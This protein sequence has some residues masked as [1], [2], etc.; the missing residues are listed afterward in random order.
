MY[1]PKHFLLDDLDQLHE[2]MTSIAAA[3]IVSQSPEGLVASHVPVELQRAPAPYGRIRC[4]LARANSHAKMIADG[5]E[6]L[7]IFQGNEG[8]ISPA[9]YPTKHSNGGKV[10][11]TWNFLAIHAYGTAT[12]FEGVDRLRPHLE[13]L[14]MR[15]E[16]GRPEP[17]SVD[18]APPEFIESMCRGIIGVEIALTRI[19]GKNK[20]SQN[21]PE[22]DRA[23][24]VAGL[25]AEGRPDLARL[26]EAAMESG[27][28]PRRP[29]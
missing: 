8:Y 23:G 11:P 26:T 4:H 2:A 6:V 18:D 12:L 27:C 20:M 17:W 14:T 5:R 13:A 24:V 15:H 29:E 9:W 7:L 1:V 21:R 19:E 3:T 22:V 25:T 10:V 16:T 28:A